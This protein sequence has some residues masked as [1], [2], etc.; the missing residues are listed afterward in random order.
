MRSP[1]RAKLPAALALSLAITSQGCVWL[2]PDEPIEN[3]DGTAGGGGGVSAGGGGGNGAG[4][5][6]AGPAGGSGG[7]EPSCQ[8]CS[9][10]DAP[11]TTP[12]N[13]VFIEPTVA[14]NS[15]IDGDGVIPLGLAVTENDVYG[16]VR[17]RPAVSGGPG[18]PIDLAGFWVARLNGDVA[19]NVVKIHECHVPNGVLYAGPI[20]A[21]PARLYTLQTSAYNVANQN[22]I[23]STS[24][25][26]LG[27]S[28]AENALT[29][30][31]TT[32]SAVNGETPFILSFDP[33]DP[34]DTHAAVVNAVI[35]EQ[36]AI[37]D[38][39]SNPTGATAFLAVGPGAAFGTPDPPGTNVAYS[40]GLLDAGGDGIQWHRFVDLEAGAPFPVIDYDGGISVDE[41]G[42]VWVIG[43]A[44]E[45]EESRAFVQYRTPTGSLGLTWFGDPGSHGITIDVLDGHVVAGID[46]TLDQTAPSG[47]VTAAGPRDF[48]LLHFDA[49]TFIEQTAA[50]DWTYP[51]TEAAHDASADDRI[52]SI[53]L[54]TRNGCATVV[55]G[56]A[57]VG[58]D[59]VTQDDVAPLLMAFDATNQSL[60]WGRDIL[61][62][63][64]SLMPTVLAVA[65]D[66][67]WVGAE[68]RGTA[69][70]RESK[71]Y[72]NGQLA[73]STWFLKLP[74]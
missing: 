17:F 56:V 5:V 53:E 2:L 28:C 50:P 70:G 31:L 26:Q 44:G 11:C 39:D 54:A 36:V 19:E 41:S 58:T 45:N 7:G 18:I 13:K 35:G 71:A 33:A 9:D 37:L 51:D 30:V 61:P 69:F 40:V 48:M 1:L 15:Q 16:A 38:I 55:Y 47:I 6:G 25:D 42:G 74:R 64:G 34:I 66:G 68:L 29:T 24:T 23:M 46:F 20:T 4:G 72:G 3:E 12:I 14:V 43:T 73:G 57:C 32:A 21:S 10:N 63:E 59:C 65:P 22:A 60:L 8:L 67:L 62:N 27:N 49:Q 52:K